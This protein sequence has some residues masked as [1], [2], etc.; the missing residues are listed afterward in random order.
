MAFTAADVKNLR[1]MTGV[2]MMDCK[3]ALTECDGD[4]DKADRVPAR[5]GS[6]QGRQ[7]GRPHRCRGYVLRHRRSNGVGVVVEVNCRDRLRAPRTSCSWPSSRT[8]PRSSPRK[9]PP[10][11]DALM[12]GKYPTALSRTVDPRP[13]R[14]RSSSIGENL[15]VRRFVRFADNTSSVRYVHAGGKIGVLVNFWLSTAASTP[16]RS[17]RTLPCRSRP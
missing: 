3:K 10:I 6:G 4:M 1:E 14:R 13:C 5:E 15:Q 11:V 8:S 17:A 2:G 9:T 16:P 12:S 7:E